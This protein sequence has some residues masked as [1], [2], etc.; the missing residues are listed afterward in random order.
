MSTSYTQEQITQFEQSLIA[1]NGVIFATF[2]DQQV[3]FISYADAQAFLADMRQQVALQAATSRGST[4][5]YG[6]TGKGV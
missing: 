1:R 3:S 4:T 6:V 2:G 5:R